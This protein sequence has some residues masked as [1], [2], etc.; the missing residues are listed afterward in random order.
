MPFCRKYARGLRFLELTFIDL[1]LSNTH[2]SDGSGFRLLMTLAGLPVTA[3]LCLPVENSCFWLPAIDGGQVCLGS[4]ALRPRE[5]A[6]A[7]QEMVRC[8]PAGPSVSLTGPKVE[9]AYVTFTESAIHRK[10]AFVS[11]NAETRIYSN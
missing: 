9:V 2:L 7:L 10:D 4:P 6:S 11:S 3:F 1:V 5:F 8:L